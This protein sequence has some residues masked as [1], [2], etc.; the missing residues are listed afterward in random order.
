MVAPLPAAW[1]ATAPVTPAA[2]GELAYQAAGYGTQVTENL[3]VQSGRSALS[4]LG[5]TAT[6]G[7]THTNTAASV[8]TPV[9]STGT[10]D[11]SAASQT[12]AT[13][14]ASVGSSTVQG[15]SLLGG[16]VGV[17]TLHSVSTTSQDSSTGVLSTSSAGTQFL[18]LNVLGIPITGTVAPNTKITLPG[19]GS[20]ILNQQYGHVYKRT[21]TMT[22]IAIHISVSLSTP[23]API[24]TQIIVGFATSSLGGPVS[25]LLSGLSYG[26][27]AKVL[28][29]AL[30]AG[31]LFPQPLGCL[32]SDGNTKTNTGVGIGI[33][34]EL[35]SGTVIDTA[36]GLDK[37][38]HPQATTTSTVEGLNLGGLVT[39]T[40][41]E[42]S[43][44]ATG[45]PPAFTDN[46]QFLGLTV[47]G[48]PGLSANPPANTK[49]KL[50]GIGTL[51]L[52][53]VTTTAT[54]ETVIMVQLDVNV[55]GNPLGLAL[56]TQVNVGY[57]TVD[58]N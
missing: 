14:P 45:N 39:A 15:A 43:V 13:G 9:L 55:A 44:S 23:L 6:A 57:A 21:A 11:T 3:V 37:A 19:V 35:T 56:G 34:G 31:N 27:R 52:H 26:A 28:G 7:I 49:L 36:E 10:I 42:A 54:T 22:V 24:G 33:L 30:L 58:I 50:P 38:K 25:G 17:T 46:S 16:L 51:W 1:G 5:C 29:G 4:T 40:A 18:G 48:F 20:V 32:G 12:T 53:K 47:S 8:T 2:S 41:V